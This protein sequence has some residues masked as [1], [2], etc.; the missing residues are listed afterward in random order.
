MPKRSGLQRR[1]K[2][3]KGKRKRKRRP[4]L[5]HMYMIQIYTDADSLGFFMVLVLGDF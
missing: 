5:R 1:P 3:R 2:W 4:L